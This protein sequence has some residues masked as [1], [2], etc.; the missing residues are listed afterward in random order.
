MK[1]T[2]IPQGL[3]LTTG[4]RE[5][6]RMKL[7]V[8]LLA[9]PGLAGPSRRQPFP[10]QSHSVLPDAHVGPRRAMSANRRP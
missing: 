1:A 6:V 2:H 8:R 4:S 3:P 10:L 7:A 5:L 9:L